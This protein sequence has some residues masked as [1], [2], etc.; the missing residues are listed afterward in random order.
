M[1]SPCYIGTSGWIYPHW[2][3]VFYPPR[4]RHEE[5]LAYYANRFSTVEINYTFYRLPEPQVFHSWAKGVPSGFLFA[6]KVSRFVTHMKKLKDPEVFL[7]RFLRAVKG[8]G[9]TLGPLLFQL[10][11]FWKADAGRLRDLLAYLRTQRI[12]RPARAAF[13]FRHPSWLTGTT[14]Q[15]LADHGAALC[16]S[17]WPELPVEGPVTADFVYLRRHGPG[18]LY[19]SRYTRRALRQD[20]ERIRALLEAGKAVYVYFNNDAQGWAVANARELR[21][22]V[23]GLGGEK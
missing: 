14:C 17:D 2:E 20:A 1:I 3:G 7:A 15:I 23:E 6:I 4:L 8:L 13:E 5:R 22:M 16:L 9:L 19:A 12:V 18:A 11:P 10:P 21:E